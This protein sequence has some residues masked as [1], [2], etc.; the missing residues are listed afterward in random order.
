MGGICGGW[1]LRPV[2]RLGLVVGGWRPWPSVWGV[3][4]GGVEVDGFLGNYTDDYTTL[5]QNDLA[6]AGFVALKHEDRRI[7]QV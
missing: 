1:T 3:L 2:K 4:F 6:R 5:T 7:E